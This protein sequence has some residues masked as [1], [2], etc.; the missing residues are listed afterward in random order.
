MS[1]HRTLLGAA[2]VS[3][4]LL[5]GAAPS[6][7]PDATAQS[8]EQAFMQAAEKMNREMMAKPMVGNADEDFASMMIAHH[9]GAID[10]AN[11]E[12]RYGTDPELRAVA[13]K[14]IDDQ[15]KEIATLQ[16]WQKGRTPVQ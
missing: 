12:L 4:G 15:T 9:Q 14:V 11:V 13:Q 1:V 6:G 5:L 7:G 3:L 2:V 16:R 10:M 8:A